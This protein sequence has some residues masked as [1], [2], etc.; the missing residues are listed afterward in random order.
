MRQLNTS[1]SGERV[2]AHITA[3]RAGSLSGFIIWINQCEEQKMSKQ[4]SGDSSKQSSSDNGNKQSSDTQKEKSGKDA[5]SH[6][7]A[8]SGKGAGGGAKQGRKH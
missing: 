7:K 2:P 1:N 5:K 8:D 4:K 3:A 6:T